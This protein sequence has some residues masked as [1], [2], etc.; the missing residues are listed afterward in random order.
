MFLATVVTEQSPWP[1]A[2]LL[3]QSENSGAAGRHAAGI[4]E[5]QDVMRPVGEF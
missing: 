3:R 4:L 5:Q 2:N 1:Q